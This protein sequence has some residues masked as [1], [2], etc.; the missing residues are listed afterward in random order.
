MTEDDLKQFLDDNKAD[1]QRAVKQKLID[2][3]LAQHQWQISGE[4]AKVVQE[5]VAAEIVPEVRNYM[6]EQKGPILE[7][8]IKGAAEIGDQLSKA[9]VERTAKKLDP[10]NY[11]FRSIL[12]ALFE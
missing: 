8:A 7:A 6:A 12:K 5:F 11:E 1:I 4:I 10:S 9:I 2:G 3:M